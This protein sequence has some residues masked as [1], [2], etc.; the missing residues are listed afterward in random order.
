MKKDVV[1]AAR[2]LAGRK[3]VAATL[4]K[5]GTKRA[6]V[7]GGSACGEPPVSPEPDEAVASVRPG[8]DGAT[9]V[10]FRPGE[11]TESDPDEQ[12]V[13]PPYAAWITYFGDHMQCRFFAVAS[14]FRVG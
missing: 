9:E 10:S 14:L 2:A 4:S 3:S 8:I 5:L 12:Q 13:N 1:R 6:K 11:E 7:E